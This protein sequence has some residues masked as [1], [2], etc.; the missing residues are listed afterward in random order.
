MSEQNQIEDISDKVDLLSSQITTI[1]I[2]LNALTVPF[3][4]IDTIRDK[5]DQLE[6]DM[7]P[8]V[9]IQSINPDNTSI[10]D[11]VRII[12]SENLPTVNTG[13]IVYNDRSLKLYGK[14]KTGAAGWLT[15]NYVV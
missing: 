7:A 6:V 13:T 12:P 1:G 15:L 3:G 9:K 11:N 8:L 10:L 14:D 5:I 2:D 4:L